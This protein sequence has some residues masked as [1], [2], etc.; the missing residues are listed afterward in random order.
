M[1]PQRS[2]LEPV[3]A[4]VHAFARDYLAGLDDRPV[5]SPRMAEALA[6]FRAPLSETGLGAQR[7]LECLAERA[8]DA[9]L[10]TGGPRSYHFVMGGATPAALGADMLAPVLDQAAYAWASSP[11]GVELEELSLG[12]LKEL[13]ALPP[14]MTGVM[15]TGATMAN[16]VALA[17]ARQWW[18]RRHGV[19]VSE[20]GLAE[21]PPVPVLSSGHL[22]ASTRKCLA[23]LGLGRGAATMLASEAPH[24]NGALDL[25][26]L[27][28]RLQALGGA[29]AIL[30]ANA[31]EVNAGAFDPIEEMASL[32][33]EFGAWLHV[34]GAF[35]LFARLSPRSAHLA[36]GAE[37]AHSITVDGHKWLNVPYDCGF[38][39][40][41][42]R[43]L[44]AQAFAYAAAYLPGSADPRPN[45]G[46]IGPESS[47]RARALAVWATLAA[48]GRAGYRALVER[49]LDLAQYLAVRVDGAPDLE[50]LAEA[51]LCI[52]CF[53]YNPGGLTEPELDEL[54]ERLGAALLED[55][56]F[57]VGTTR[58]AG[59]VAFRPALV[60]WRIR[61]RDLDEFV[62]VVRET[63][64]RVATAR[65]ARSTAR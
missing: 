36:A 1:D 60:N 22:H 27:R 38:A 28:A 64:A 25:A 46:A 26:A 48:Y 39:F 7:A 11:L 49:H 24:A 56:R 58:H 63:G 10:A 3:L 23:M 59:R 65:T 21:L 32:A 8:R 42:D 29:P 35:G 31:G 20:R 4:S 61:E 40:V 12:W 55:G 2:E 45:F 33:E 41:R 62:R 51:P 13:F 34:D 16:F 54:N 47:R 52:V 5:R 14:A 19:D 30:V 37:R 53:R 57:W 18:G 15:T 17:A 6:A 43:E 44:L 9:A 50:R